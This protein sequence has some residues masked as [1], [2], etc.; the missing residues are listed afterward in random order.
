MHSSTRR[1]VTFHMGNAALWHAEAVNIARLPAA[2]SFA[3]TPRNGAG[4]CPRL[5]WRSICRRSPP[6]RV[7]LKRRVPPAIT[8]DDIVLAY[9]TPPFL[10]IFRLR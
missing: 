4:V 5:G 9:C 1:H 8:G 3:L 7:N 10:T 2:L 6:L